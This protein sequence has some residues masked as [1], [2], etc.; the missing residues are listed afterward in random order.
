MGMDT[1]CHKFMFCFQRQ[2][3][4][5]NYIHSWLLRCSTTRG[6]STGL[7]LVGPTKVKARKSFLFT[8][9]LLKVENNKSLRM[10]R[11]LVKLL[12]LVKTMT[13]LVTGV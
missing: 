3:F 8:E 9:G 10:E 5:H 11:S 1:D 13:N 4:L 2:R 7:S 6:P 12:G